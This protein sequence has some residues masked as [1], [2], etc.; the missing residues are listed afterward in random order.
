V[1]QLDESI[2]LLRRTP[3]SLHALLDGLPAA[4]LTANEGP[5]TWSCRDVLAHLADL[6]DTDW[7]MRMKLILDRGEA[8]PFTPI[9]RERFRR[10]LGTQSVP[11]LLGLFAERRQRNLDVIAARRLTAVDLSRRGT[12][13]DF[14]SVTLAQLL[15]A[16]TVHDLTHVSQIVRVMAKR[17][18]DDVGPWQAY[19][20]VLSRERPVQTTGER[21]NVSGESPSPRLLPDPLIP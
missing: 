12:H 19:L 9:D 10:V 14:G 8:A 15:A 2:A 11:E 13:P 16:W 1:F 17:Y 3:A 7:P 20:S 18:S 21:P 5:N 6:E 4:W